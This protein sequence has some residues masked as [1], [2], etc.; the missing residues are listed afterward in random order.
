MKKCPKCKHNKNVLWFFDNVYRQEFLVIFAPNHKKFAEILKKESGFEV[1]PC[2][3]ECVTGQFNELKSK[4][5]SL[6]V[7]WSSDKNL[8]LLHET[9]HA[10]SC[11]LGQRSIFLNP[12]T[13]ESYSYYYTYLIRTIQE[14]LK[15]G[16]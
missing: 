12:E 1:E 8:V 3:E 11:I 14:Y 10:C 5:G 2:N 7:I 15:N 13:E 4:C 9:F 16:Q 6:A